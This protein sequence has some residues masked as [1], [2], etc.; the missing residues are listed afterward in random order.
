M[1]KYVYLRKSQIISTAYAHTIYTVVP[2]I[3]HCCWGCKAAR[4]LRGYVTREH[5]CTVKKFSNTAYIYILRR[6]RPSSVRVVML[7]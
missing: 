2:R 5:T 6:S 7:T 1:Y 3:L 4:K